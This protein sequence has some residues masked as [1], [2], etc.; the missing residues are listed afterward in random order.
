MIRIHK[1]KHKTK[2]E[3]GGTNENK[4]KSSRSVYFISSAAG[5]VYFSIVFIVAFIL[6]V[7]RVTIFVPRFGENVAVLL[8]TPVVLSVSWFAALW[9]S[10][11]FQV[12]SALVPRLIMGLVAGV[13]LLVAEDTLAVC[14][15]DKTTSEFLQELL[16]T[17]THQIIGHTGQ[18]AYALIPMAQGYMHREAY[19]P[20]R[21]LNE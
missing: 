3:L 9:S 6:G 10:E 8:E 11:N 12:P 5:A 14:L 18:L 21:S 15:F 7:A 13:T 1:G 19:D 17:E 2:D 16:S 20:K 4:L